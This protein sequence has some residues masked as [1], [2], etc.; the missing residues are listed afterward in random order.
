M[1]FSIQIMWYHRP[2]LCPHLWNS[3][4]LTKPRWAWKSALLVVRY[5]S[6]V[7]GRR[8]LPTL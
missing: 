4:T 2:N 6:S 3:P 8:D 5:S 1:I 7:S